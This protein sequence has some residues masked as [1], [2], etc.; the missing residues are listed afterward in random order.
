MPMILWTRYFLEAQGYTIQENVVYQDNKSAMLLENN[1]KASSTKRTRQINIR[2]YFV[3]DRIK[4]GEVSV[5]HCPTDD[6]TADYFTKPTQ[7]AKFRKFRAEIM[8][9]PVDSSQNG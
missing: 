4:A 8:N 7:G 9:L 1:G 5:S 2:Y 3:T 6:M